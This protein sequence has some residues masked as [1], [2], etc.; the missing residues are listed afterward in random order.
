MY[1]IAVHLLQLRFHLA[2]LLR[3]C[4]QVSCISNTLTLWPGHTDREDLSILILEHWTPSVQLF[5]KHKSVKTTKVLSETPG[6]YG[7]V[8]SFLHEA[9]TSVRPIVLERPCRLE[10]DVGQDVAH[11]AR[12]VKDIFESDAVAV[13]LSWLPSN[14]DH[15][16]SNAE[17]GNFV[18]VSK[19]KGARFEWSVG[20]ETS[21]VGG[22]MNVRG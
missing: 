9:D 11:S 4:L 6:S 18:L 15:D 19:G 3:R 20:L 12:H 8:P 13:F 5:R 7:A 17:D 22:D 14:F 16:C 10:I 21:M 1:R 2:L